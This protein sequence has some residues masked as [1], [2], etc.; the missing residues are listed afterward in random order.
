[1]SK[2]HLY[3]AISRFTGWEKQTAGFLIRSDGV[4]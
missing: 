3:Q 4:H 1:M 2:E